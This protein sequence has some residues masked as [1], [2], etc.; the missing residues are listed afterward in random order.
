[1]SVE[2]TGIASKF[3]LDS[4]L[5]DDDYPNCSQPDHSHLNEHPS[6]NQQSLKSLWD[7]SETLTVSLEIRIAIGVIVEVSYEPDKE[8]SMSRM[9]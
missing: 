5:I 8:A 7:V 2:D 9:D 3:R 4:I 1:M 6:R